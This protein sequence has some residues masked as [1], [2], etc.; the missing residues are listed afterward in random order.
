MLLYNPKTSKTIIK[1]FKFNLNNVAI[2]NIN[3]DKKGDIWVGI[4][5][6]NGR[7][8]KGCLLELDY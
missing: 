4:N 5:Y 3:I 8:I 7:Y 6:S 2:D 1:K